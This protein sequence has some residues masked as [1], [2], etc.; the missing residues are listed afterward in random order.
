MN[1]GGCFCGGVRYEVTKPL[2]AVAYCHCSKCRRWHGHVG[3]YTAVDRDGLVLTET[4]GLAWHTV[5]PTVQRG[6]C[7]EC[8]SS[9]FF[10]E[11]TDKKISLCP[12][13]LDTPTGIFE[14]AHIYTASKGDYYEIAG[15][16]PQ[17]ETM[18]VRHKP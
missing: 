1:T 2:T 5:S 4:R 3:A 6:F 9:L 18:P 12:G 13:T 10:D 15:S 7:R 16:L 14:K 8:G 17:Y 11:Q